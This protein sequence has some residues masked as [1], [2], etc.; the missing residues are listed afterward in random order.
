[1]DQ[2]STEDPIVV[3][4]FCSVKAAEVDKMHPE[5]LN[6]LGAVRVSCT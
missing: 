5:M 2:W 4:G 6:A 3:K 1:M